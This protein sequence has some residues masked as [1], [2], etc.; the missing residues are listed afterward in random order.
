MRP[1]DGRL[2]WDESEAEST[3]TWVSAMT[4]QRRVKRGLNIIS[5]K[6]NA[7]QPDA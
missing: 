2:R 4:V 1:A 6:L 3:T 7:V 5:K